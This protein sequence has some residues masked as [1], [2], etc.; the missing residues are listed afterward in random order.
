MEGRVSL[1]KGALI[2]AVTREGGGADKA[3]ETCG[4]ANLK[5]LAPQSTSLSG[6][7]ARGG[8]SVYTSSGAICGNL[9]LGP[10]QPDE[11]GPTLS[12]AW[13]TR[14]TSPHCFTPL[15]APSFSKASAARRASDLASSSLRC[16][17]QMVACRSIA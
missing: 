2:Y 5:N 12:C 13:I 6:P 1:T 17:H 10:N 15:E 14:R 4:G 16:L 3:F 9:Q 7:L 11:T 8:E